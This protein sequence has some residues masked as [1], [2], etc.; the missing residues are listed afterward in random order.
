MNPSV[1]ESPSHR[2][3]IKDVRCEGDLTTLYD[4]TY[5]NGGGDHQ[6][7]VK[8]ARDKA[9]NDFVWNEAGILGYIY[10]PSQPD[11]KLYKLFPRLLDAFETK[12][13]RRANVFARIDG[14][15]S[16][17]EIIR[18]YPG[19]IE[20]RHM[21]WMYKR[22]LVALG[23][24]H[25]KGIVHGAVL[26]SHVLVHPTEHGAKLLDWSY[27]L[28]FAEIVKPKTKGSKKDPDPD[29]TP[30]THHKARNAWEKLLEDADYD[31]DPVYTALPKGPPAD[32]S[33]MY[34][35]AMS[36][37]Y[38]PF[39]APEILVKR[40]PTPATD[41]F[42]AAKCMVALLGGDV[43][44]NQMPDAVPSQIKAFLQSSLTPATRHRPQDVWDLHEAFDRLMQGLVGPNKYVPF[45]M[46]AKS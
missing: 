35:R 36:V 9:D 24:A 46:P 33:R 7:V 27:A 15:V 8:I 5:A 18:A 21:V 45:S 1:I 23:L 17:E 14:Y 32:P 41:A 6:V 40:T 26:P 2:Y 25:T 37:A 16:F 38:E 29:P 19:G 34:V 28:N 12:E 10:P 20:F 39:Y 4:A 42:M 3:V 11:E 31:P 30:G 13:G 22:L 44:T 43:E